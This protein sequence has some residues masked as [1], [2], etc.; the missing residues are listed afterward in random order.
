MRRTAGSGDRCSLPSPGLRHPRRIKQPRG[1][2]TAGS[3][4]ED[5]QQEPELLVHIV[6]I[7]DR[8]GDDAPQALPKSMPD[9]VEGDLQ[10]TPG[11]PQIPG[12]LRIVRRVVADEKGP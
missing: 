2:L 5:R 9:P 1:V 8:L 10:R 7:L 12:Q 6:W 11:H 4:T 3:S